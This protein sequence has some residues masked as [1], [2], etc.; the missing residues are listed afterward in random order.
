MRSFLPCLAVFL[1]LWQAPAQDFK[2]YTEH[3]RLFLRPQRL[4]LL[5]REK[6]RQSMRWEQFEL[7][8]AGKAAMP[9]P[10]FARA[11]YYQISGN[12]QAGQQAIRWALGAGAELRQVALVF[13][14]CQ[15]LLDPQQSKALAEKLQRGLEPAAGARSLPA[16]RTHVLAAVALADH[17]PGAPEVALRS[18]VEQW[19][20]REMVPALKAGRNLV[21]RDDLYAL[22][23]MLHALRD[24]LNLDLRASVPAFFKPL[25]LYDLMSYYPASYPAAENEYR[26][27][28]TPGAQPDLRRAALAR[29]AEFAMLAYDPNS[30]ENQYLQGW[31]MHDRYLLRGAF[32]NPYEFLWANPYHP[33]LSYYNLPPVF[34]DEL[35][36]RVFLRSSWDDNA[37]W[38]GYFDRQLQVFEKGQPRIVPLKS[39]ANP[40]L[41][42]DAAVIA[43]RSPLRFRFSSEVKTVF[44]IGLEPLR[45]YDVEVDD[46]EMREQTTD[47]GG[48]LTLEFPAGLRGGVR[49]NPAPL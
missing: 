28:A 46:E 12:Q 47:R 49:I 22:F 26:I 25:A 11:L 3:P 36:G 38:L 37:V 27:P 44:V 32:G 6:E 21:A 35:F 1:G 48:I 7:L 39:A 34:H 20:N 8:M 18:V 33:G 2:I 24:N 4:R 31:L 10:G 30:V 40:I 15:S 23:E 14:W 41:V 5:K 42:G 19:W 29:A 13:D 43:A 16:M 9:E 45:G 17:L